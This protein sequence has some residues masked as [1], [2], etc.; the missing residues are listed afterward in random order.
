MMLRYR[1]IHECY[2]IVTYVSSLNEPNRVP[3]RT[4]LDLGQWIE[5]RRKN[6]GLTQMDVAARAGLSRQLVSRIEH[7]AFGS[8]LTRVLAVIRALDSYLLVETNDAS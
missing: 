7:G 8:E 4:S 2:G 6:L 3:I 5:G 1:V